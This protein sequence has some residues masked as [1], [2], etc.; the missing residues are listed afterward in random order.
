[1]AGDSTTPMIPNR[2]QLFGRSTRDSSAEDKWM[3]GA[4]CSSPVASFT[5]E[6]SKTVKFLGEGNVSMGV[7]WL[8]V[9]GNSRHCK[10]LSGIVHLQLT[11]GNHDHF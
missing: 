5:K 10:S 6:I 11:K 4:N 9:S 7:P 2:S 3:E 1:M 8:N